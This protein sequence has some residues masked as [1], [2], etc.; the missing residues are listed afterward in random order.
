[1]MPVKISKNARSRMMQRNKNSLAFRANGKRNVRSTL[2]CER[3]EPRCMLTTGAIGDQFVV[4]EAAGFTD[5]PAAIAVLADATFTMAWE[6]FQEDG[7]G[8]GIFAQRFDSNGVPMSSKVLVN[9]TT[10]RDQSA[11]N[12]AVDAAGNH[13]VVWQSKGQDGSGF[14]VYGQWLDYAGTKMGPEF[15]INTT[16]EG[17]QIAP[18]VAIDGLGRVKRVHRREAVGIFSPDNTAGMVLP[19][20]ANCQSTRGS[21]APRSYP[22]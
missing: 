14:G 20:V 5:T 4:A 21:S 17:D 8:F 3:L 18:A 13:L 1:M 22:L 9:S 19:K 16:T 12:I 2:R 10:D 15:R 11:P 6:S 7:S